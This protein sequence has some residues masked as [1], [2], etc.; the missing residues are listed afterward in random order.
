MGD[1]VPKPGASS[2]T[3]QTQQAM[4]PAIGKQPMI[5]PASTTSAPLATATP[6]TTRQATSPSAGVPTA[7][8]QVASPQAGIDKSGFVDNSAGA[9]LYNKPAE[10]GGALVRDAPLPPA[11]RVFVS[12]TA[13][14]HPRWL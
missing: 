13:A 8:L 2:L 3:Q 1:Y 14:Y 6:K 12:G 4:G 9:P 5:Q 7:Q 11:A 10:V